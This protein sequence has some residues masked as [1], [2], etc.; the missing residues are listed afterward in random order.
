MKRRSATSRRGG[1]VWS[2]NSLY[3]EDA[4]IMSQKCHEPMK[5]F[6]SLRIRS[7]SYHCPGPQDPHDSNED[8]DH[9]YPGRFQCLDVFQD[10]GV[11]TACTSFSIV[12]GKNPK[13]GNIS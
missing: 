2:P 1:I 5:F 7:G 11:H 6:D 4:A 13:G 12:S 8:P 10:E 3:L 9:Q